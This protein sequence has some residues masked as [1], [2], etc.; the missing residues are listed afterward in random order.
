MANNHQLAPAR[1]GIVCAPSDLSLGAQPMGPRRIIRRI[2]L[3]AIIVVVVLNWTWGKLPAEPPAPAGSKYAQVGDTKIHYIE[4]PGREPAVVMVHGL[5]GTWADWDAVTKALPGQRTIAIDRPGFGYSSGGYVAFDEQVKA[6][7][8]FTKQLKLDRPVIAGHSY[9]G[10]LAFAYADA[11]PRQTRGIVA[12]DPAVV[13]SDISALE[14]IQAQLVGFLQLP[15]IEPISN[16][17]FSQAMRTA[18]ANRGDE[19]AFAP[20]PVD[21]GHKQRLLELN[22][23]KEDLKAF[24]KEIPAFGS[25]ADQLAA[26]YASITTPTWIVQGKDDK[27]VSTP[28]VQR[29]A[30]VIP[31]ARLKLVSGG[32]MATYTHPDAVAAAIAAAAR[33]R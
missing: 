21:A 27:L 16:A 31:N 19:E 10:A 8:V 32:H 6:I 26:R 13:S 22:M 11:Y 12:V 9:G 15:I 7:N 2:L 20:D 28:E 17:T 33:R 30:R 18:A 14:Q 25:V 29:V 1:R 24:S 5:P 23:K 4:K 3:A